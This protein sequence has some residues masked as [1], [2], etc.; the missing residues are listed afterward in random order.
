M[1]RSFYQYAIHTWF[2]GFN[3]RAMSYRDST[4]NHIFIHFLPITNNHR[5]DYEHW[6]SNSEEEFCPELRVARSF[7]LEMPRQPTRPLRGC[8]RCRSKS[9]LHRRGRLQLRKQAA[10]LVPAGVGR[11]RWPI[12]G[13]NFL[14]RCEHR[15]QLLKIRSARHHQGA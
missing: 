13:S 10:C 1:I 12:R 14:Y 15:A 5:D 3:R 2:D 11:G 9:S 6:S 4:D 7:L 8:A